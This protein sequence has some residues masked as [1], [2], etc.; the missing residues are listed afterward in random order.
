[1]TSD[2]FLTPTNNIYS[3]PVAA[4]LTGTV[5]VS[6][7]SGQTLILVF[8]RTGAT[9]EIKSE[10][11]ISAGDEY[12]YFALIDGNADIQLGGNGGSGTFVAVQFLDE[13]NQRRF[14]LSVLPAS[15]S[16]SVATLELEV[17]QPPEGQN[18]DLT[19]LSMYLPFPAETSGRRN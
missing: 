15:S 12:D 4:A 13:D 1:M 19:K 9:I 11:A 16:V 3:F 17:N 2:R 8:A 18:A 10:V 6:H 14:T 7:T 5:T